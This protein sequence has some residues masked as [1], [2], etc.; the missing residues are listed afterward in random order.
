MLHRFIDE[1]L[2]EGILLYF[3]LPL[4]L[5]DFFVQTFVDGSYIPLVSDPFLVDIGGERQSDIFGHY[6][7]IKGIHSCCRRGLAMENVTL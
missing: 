2:Y 5:K 3:V 7:D 1:F 4:D 6:I